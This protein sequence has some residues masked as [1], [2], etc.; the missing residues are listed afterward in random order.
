MIKQYRDGLELNSKGESFTL[1]NEAL[2]EVFYT[3][4]GQKRYFATLLGRPFSAHGYTVEEAVEEAKIKR[5]GQRKL[6]EEEKSKLRADGYKFSV[7]E[8]RRITGACNAGIDDW[9]KKRGLDRS[10]K[11]TIDELRTAGASDWAE[12]LKQ[13]LI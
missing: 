9:L 13:A 10:V 7:L 11:M 12:S 4:S 8:F 3:D 5:D 2:I 1:G 6:S